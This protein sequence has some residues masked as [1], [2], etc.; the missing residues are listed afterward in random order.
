MGVRFYRPGEHQGGFIGFR[1]TRTVGDEYKQRYFST[2]GLSE[3]DF[4]FR[5]LKVKAQLVDTEWKVESLWHQYK[6]FVTSD[7]PNTKPGRGTGVHGITLGFTHD[8]RDRWVG[9]FIVQLS[10]KKGAHKVYFGTRLY[11][12][13]WKEAVNAWADNYEILPEDYDRVLNNPPPP[14]QFKELRRIM[15]TEGFNIPVTALRQVFTEQRE[16]I[17]MKRPLA[18]ASAKSWAAPLLNPDAKTMDEEMKAWF[19]R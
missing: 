6:T 1:V 17:R 18:H 10:R 2:N 19:E 7:H 15:N 11:S 13:A 4:W 14:E 8:R 16:E 5:Y 3:D 12:E 9:C